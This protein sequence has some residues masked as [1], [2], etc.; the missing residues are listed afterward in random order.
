LDGVSAGQFADG[1]TFTLQ[2]PEAFTPEQVVEIAD[3]VLYHPW[4]RGYLREAVRP[5]P[6]AACQG[7]GPRIWISEPSGRKVCQ[8]AV[9][10]SRAMVNRPS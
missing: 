8:T 4:P 1:T 2:A 9:S 5:V 7:L 10:G 6:L 3:Q